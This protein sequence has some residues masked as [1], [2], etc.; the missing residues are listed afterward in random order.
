MA[1]I[2]AQLGSRRYLPK[3]LTSDVNAKGRFGKQDFVCVG[4][5]DVYLCAPVNG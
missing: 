1:V 2:A 5:D 4:A 3:P